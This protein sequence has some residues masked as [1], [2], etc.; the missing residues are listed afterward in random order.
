MAAAGETYLQCVLPYCASRLN[1]RSLACLAASSRDLNSSCLAIIKRDAARLWHL[2]M[3]AAEAA[4]INKV[5]HTVNLST[6]MLRQA[7]AWLLRTLPTAAGIAERII[8]LP[9]VPLHVAQQLVAGGVRFNHKQLLAAARD[10]APGVDV[11]V[12]AHQQLGITT[13][14][15]AAWFSVC[16]PPALKRVSSSSN[17]CKAAAKGTLHTP[18][19]S[20]LLNNRCYSCL[21][22]NRII[23]TACAPGQ[24]D[25]AAC[26]VC[27]VIPH[28]S[29]WMLRRF[30]Y[31][32]ARQSTC[33]RLPSMAAL[34]VR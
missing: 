13:D 17:L 32:K 22:T 8:R 12:Q 10:M 11:W 33:C 23:Q 6:C 1:L 9:A 29:C 3:D 24:C 20:S 21:K 34:A 15:P 5:S 25:A 7:G 4:A 26:G 19:G 16:G 30:T 14:I 27:H 31:Q 18:V 2:D 28:V